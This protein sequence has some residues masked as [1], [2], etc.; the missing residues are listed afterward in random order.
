MIVDIVGTHELPREGLLGPK[1]GVSR[2]DP[3]RRNDDQKAAAFT[4][5]P[6]PLHAGGVGARHCPGGMMAKRGM[7]ALLG[8]LMRAFPRLTLAASAAELR[9]WLQG[10]RA[11]VLNDICELLYRLPLPVRREGLL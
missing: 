4:P 8:E 5:P 9:R 7:A 2:W 10:Y 11:E 3:M 6:P 1:G